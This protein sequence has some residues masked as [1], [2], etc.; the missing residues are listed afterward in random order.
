MDTCGAPPVQA[1]LSLSPL[2]F[3]LF[4]EQSDQCRA[5]LCSRR[6]KYQELQGCL[7]F[8]TITALSGQQLATPTCWCHISCWTDAGVWRVNGTSSR[9]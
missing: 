6:S 4:H 5:A 9:G 7:S 2:A 3:A 1:R 8:R